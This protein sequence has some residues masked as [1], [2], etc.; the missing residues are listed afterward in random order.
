MT[1]SHH[2]ERFYSAYPKKEGRGAALKSWQKI[3]NGMG[4]EELEKFTQKIVT[5]INAQ[6][7]SRWNASDR[8]YIP[9]PSTWL[10]QCRWD[11]EIQS[12]IEK[13]IT[14]YAVIDLCQCGQKAFNRK[15][16][17]RC[18]TK[19]ANPELPDLMKDTLRKHGFTK[20]SGESWRSAC[21][22]VL[23]ENNLVKLLPDSIK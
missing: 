21:M 7:L 11:D 2:W 18:Y 13:P 4:H 3:T 16:C 22:R 5:A 15:L 1:D 6:K 9:M 19:L 14:K 12:S 17:A 23:Y 8:K 10:N 20:N